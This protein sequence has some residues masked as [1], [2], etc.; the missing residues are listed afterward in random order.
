MSSYL[1][2]LLQLALVDTGV[3]GQ[4]FQF[5]GQNGQALS[6][7]VEKVRGVISNVN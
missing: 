3:S 6:T 7:A 5:L 2:Q 4:K 1:N